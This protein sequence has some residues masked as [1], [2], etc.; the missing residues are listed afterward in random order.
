AGDH[1]RPDRLF[2]SP[3]GGLQAGAA[4]EGEDG[5]SLTAKMTGQPAVASNATLNPQGAIQARLQAARGDGQAVR[6]DAIAIP[7]PAQPQ[8]LQQQVAHRARQLRP[9][10]RP[11]FDQFPAAA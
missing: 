11:D 10:R 8:R 3:V 9:R 5:A 4:Q 6:A 2:G 7:Q 1:H